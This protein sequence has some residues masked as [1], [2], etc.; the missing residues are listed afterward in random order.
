MP[1]KRYNIWMHTDLINQ[2]K[3]AAKQMGVK[4]STYIRIATIEKLNL[5]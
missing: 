2:V 1:N 4:T 5:K 3:K